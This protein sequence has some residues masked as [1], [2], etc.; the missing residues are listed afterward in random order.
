MKRAFTLIELLVV[1][2]IIAILAAILFPVFA[3]AKAAAKATV[4][5]SN[6]KQM[7][8]ALQLYVNDWDDV[9]F[10]RGGWVNSR[11][12]DTKIIG[13]GDSLNHY[14]WWNLLM[15]YMKSN[16]MAACPEDPLPTPS[17]DSNGV[18]DIL[19]SYIAVS[20]A[21]S[22]NLSSLPTPTDTIVLTEKWG[23]DYT[24]IRT[25]SWIEPYNGDFTT[26]K[27]DSTRTFTAANRHFGK[28]NA[29]FFDGHAKSETPGAIQSS[30]DLTGCQLVY[31]F[32]YLGPNPPTVYSATSAPGQPNI[33]STFTWP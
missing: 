31:S 3:Q 4:C 19:R 1:I 28:M 16:N 9:M 11:S 32:P 15:P 24:G 12:G 7:G 27:T 30:K 29:V 20:C 10:Y 22:L 18:E 13:P 21:E 8:L 5:L 26:D 6:N 17:V 25:D 14:K 23:Q 2:A 33:C